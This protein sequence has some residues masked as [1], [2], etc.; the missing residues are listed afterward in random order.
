MMCPK[1]GGLLK[2]YPDSSIS[3]YASRSNLSLVHIVGRSLSFWSKPL[4]EVATPRRGAL[5]ILLTGSTPFSLRMTQLT[6]SAKSLG[7][8]SL[9][10]YAD[11]SR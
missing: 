4:E 9:R 10:S 11:A 6:L 7:V 5:V 2:S 1:N 8:L 3:L